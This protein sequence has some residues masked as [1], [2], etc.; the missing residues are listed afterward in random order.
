MQ[1][2]LFLTM[3]SGVVAPPKELLKKHRQKFFDLPFPYLNHS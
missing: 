3:P 2:N 1:K